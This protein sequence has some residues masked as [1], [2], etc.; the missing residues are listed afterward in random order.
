MASDTALNA[1]MA[2]LS[3]WEIAGYASFAA[4]VIGVAGE[5]VHDFIP[6]L[7]KRFPWWNSWG[8][9]VSGL[10]LIIALAAE[11]ITQVKTNNISGQIIAFLSDQAASARERAA[12]LEKQAA[13]LRVDLERERISTSARLWTK[14][15]FDAIQEIKGVVTD[16]GIL[17]PEHCVECHELGTYIEIALHSARVQIYGARGVPDAIAT[18]IFVRLPRQRS[19]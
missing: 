8:G 16:V 13:Q 9:K 1:L 19:E 6:S 12:S 5:F 7:K 4:V 17:W 10:V 18:G 2:S 15:Q 3:S 14:E 11:L